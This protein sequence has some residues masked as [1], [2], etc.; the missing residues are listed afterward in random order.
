MFIL[1]ILLFSL[2]PFFLWLFVYIISAF[3]S[4]KLEK[5]SGREIRVLLFWQLVSFGFFAY[6]VFIDLNSE[7]GIL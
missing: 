2:A 3:L 4:W 6:W 7:Y 5:P 1:K